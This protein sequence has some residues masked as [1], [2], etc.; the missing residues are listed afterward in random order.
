MIYLEFSCTLWPNTLLLFSTSKI[1]HCSQI[2]RSSSFC[3][4][5]LFVCF[6]A[7]WSSINKCIIK[8][9]WAFML[10]A[11]NMLGYMVFAREPCLWGKRGKLGDLH[12]RDGPYWPNL[13]KALRNSA[14]LALPS[15]RS[16]K[17]HQ[18]YSTAMATIVLF[19]PFLASSQ[20]INNNYLTPQPIGFSKHQRRVE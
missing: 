9:I 2:S 8:S 19:P 17:W 10:V 14:A 6:T 12:G 13:A 15:N 20:S 3:R 5:C 16:P 18:H 1:V 11:V 4:F 7:Q